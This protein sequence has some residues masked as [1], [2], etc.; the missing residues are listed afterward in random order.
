VTHVS[1]GAF[2]VYADPAIPNSAELRVRRRWLV[3]G[4]NVRPLGDAE[5]FWRAVAFGGHVEKGHGLN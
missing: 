1:E 5:S 4:V 2:A 3:G